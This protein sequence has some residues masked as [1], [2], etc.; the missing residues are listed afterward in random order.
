MIHLKRPRRKRPIRSSLPNHRLWVWSSFSRI[1]LL[2]TGNPY[3]LA[4]E[5]LLSADGL[6]FL[7]MLSTQRIAASRASVHGVLT[8][9]ALSSPSSLTTNSA[10]RRSGLYLK[11]CCVTEITRFRILTSVLSP[12]SCP[13]ALELISN[14]LSRALFNQL[15]WCSQKSLPCANTINLLVLKNTSKMEMW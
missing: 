6:A 13:T 11:P 10:C 4:L 9:F 2:Q 7:E 1:L 14:L 5:S 3:G 8:D 15:N 12:T